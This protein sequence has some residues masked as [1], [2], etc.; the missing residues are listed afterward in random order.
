MKANRIKPK[1]S[2]IVITYN[3]EDVIRRALDSLVKQIDYIFEICVSDDCSKDRTWDILQEYKTN[4][5]TVFNINRN[6]P[7]LGIFQN[8]EQS[9]TMPSGD[10]VYQMA[11][12][13]EVPIGWFKT[14]ADFMDGIDWQ[15]EK[16]CIYSNHQCIYPNGDTFVIK[17]NNRV[18]WRYGLLK[19]YEYGLLNGRG[20]C[21]SIDVLK[22]F[23]KCSQGR[24]YIAENAQDGQLHFFTEKAYYIPQVGNIYYSGIGVSSTMMA[25][26]RRLEHENTMVY[27]FAFFK[28]L[29]ERFTPAYSRLPQYNIALKRFRHQQS[30]KNY[31][32]VIK[33]YIASFDLNICL[34]NIDFKR[35]LFRIVRRLPH[36]KPINWK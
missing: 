20:A 11:G 2:V 27:A 16:F 22:S 35:F 14:V 26:E 8:I 17:K 15:H 1:F 30:L 33:A 25:D 4:Y 6:D 3:Q 7:N 28:S 32:N 13:D 18:N 23:R 21:F 31:F 29:G 34:R 19:Q 12:D 36:K 5:P 10:V 24:S 9:W